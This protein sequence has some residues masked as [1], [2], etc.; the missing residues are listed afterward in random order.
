[1][2]FYRNLQRLRFSVL[3]AMHFRFS[4]SP[5]FACNRCTVFWQILKFWTPYGGHRWFPMPFGISYA[6]K[7]FQCRQHEVTWGLQWVY[8]IADDILIYACGDAEEFNI[9]HDKNLLDLLTAPCVT[10][11]T[12]S[13]ESH[14]VELRL[15][16]TTIKPY[17]V[18]NIAWRNLY[19]EKGCWWT[20]T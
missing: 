3:H 5:C 11:A 7:A 20:S 6:T 2:P 9:D 18:F 15:T 12:T 4:G 19:W 13:T 17:C 1:M 8:V 10:R 14:Q 16:R